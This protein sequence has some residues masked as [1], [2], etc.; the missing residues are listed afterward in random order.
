M[1]GF[2]FATIAELHAGF[3]ARA[4]SP[5]EVLAD[6]IR[7]L[8]VIEPRLNMFAHLDLEGAQAQARAAE[9]R[10]MQGAR[11]GPLDGVPTSVKDLIAVAGMP[12]RFGSRTTGAEPAA[13]DAPSV[14]RLRAGG[15]VFLGKSTTSEFGCKAVGDSPLTGITRN[16]WDPDKTPGGSS[17]GAAAMVACGLVP[18]ALGTDGGGSLRIPAALTGLYG[19]KAQFGRVPVFPTSA[20]PTLAH[21]GPLA[22]RADDVAAV[23]SV[24][25]GYDGRDPFSLAGPAPDFA[26]ALVRR[27]PLRIAFCPTLGYARVDAEVADIT[28]R[29]LRG[30]AGAGHH[31]DRIDP[32]FDDPAELWTAEFYAGVAVRLRPA[33]EK[34]PDLLD[35]AVLGVLRAAVALDMRSYY[36]TVFRRYAFR[37]TVRALMEPYDVLVTPTLP[38]AAIDVGVDVPPSQAERTIVSWA[39]FTYPFNLTGQPAVSMPIG[40]TAAGL[41]VGLQ[42][43]AN[44][45]DEETLLS[46]AAENDLRLG[47]A[48][49]RP[50]RAGYL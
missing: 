49:L 46:L 15:A 20:T 31:V 21:V 8:Q 19:F 42:V 45:M 9:T 35:P 24:I 50:E 2:A 37:E 13:Q 5:V 41:P 11:L 3:E 30:F 36:E 23:M 26:G 34:T 1:T 17:A 48:G 7:R 16:P 39:S 28:A 47:K 29:A 12:Q 44:A 10:M 33:L 40:L 27:R 4:F 18:Y 43:V 22:R 32:F 6:V 14:S 38:V 25:A